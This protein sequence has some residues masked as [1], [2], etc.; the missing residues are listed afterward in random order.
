MGDYQR[1]HSA[2]PTS[3]LFVQRS[4]VRSS[5]RYRQELESEAFT[6]RIDPNSN[7]IASR[8]RPRTS[9]PL[10]D[11]LQQE[12]EAW[13]MKLQEQRLIRDEQEVHGCTFEPIAA[14][15]IDSTELDAGLGSV[16]AIRLGGLML[17]E[18]EY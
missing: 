14:E 18:P 12:K 11:Q 2:T 8:H 16:R 1:E 15:R 10:H 7:R 6:P 5:D 17:T 4:R 3:H 9:T 13:D